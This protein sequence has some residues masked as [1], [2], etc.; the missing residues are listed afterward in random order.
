MI[1]RARTEAGVRFDVNSWCRCVNHNIKIGGSATSSHVLG[2][3]I[4]ISYKDDEDLHLKV[5]ALHEVGFVRVLAYPKSMFIH[6][7]ISSEK[8]QPIFKIMEQG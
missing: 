5:K 7:D 6:V 3:A 4:D 8:K 1:D 2:E